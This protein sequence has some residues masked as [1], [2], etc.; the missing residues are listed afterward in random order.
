VFAFW[1]ISVLYYSGEQIKKNETAVTCGTIRERRVADRVL[2]R[3][4][5]G[6]A[7]LGR[8]RYKWEDNIKMNI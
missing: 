5:E 1:F 2:V 4:P 7:L 3:K 8:S 6:K